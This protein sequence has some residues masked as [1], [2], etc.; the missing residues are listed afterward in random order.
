MQSIGVANGQEAVR[1]NEYDVWP[2]GA[3][4]G[5]YECPKW[6]ISCHLTGI[7]RCNFAC[8]R[9]VI[10]S[11]HLQ[12]CSFENEREAVRKNEKGHTIWPWPWPIDF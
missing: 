5:A 10:G 12:S 7:F 2:F 3:L 9:I 6:P 8:D 4:A 11:D 1:K